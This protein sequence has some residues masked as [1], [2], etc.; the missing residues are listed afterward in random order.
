M[1]NTIGALTALL[2]VGLCTSPTEAQSSAD[3]EPAAARS[4][5]FELTIR[6]IMR[7]PE[8]VGQGPQQVRWTDDARWIYF[9]WLPGGNA[10]HDSRELFRIPADGGEPEPLDDAA[11]DSAEVLIASGDLSRDRGLRVSSVG[12]DLYLVNRADMSVR[13]LFETVE[14]E[15][16]PSFSSDDSEVFFRR[17]SRRRWLG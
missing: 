6:S 10:W 8:L 5:P 7:G 14:P 9:R 4:Q 16:S 2:A 11:A 13:R 3:F 15:S 1:R 17:A 12:G